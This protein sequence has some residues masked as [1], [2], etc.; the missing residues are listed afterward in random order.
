MKI[1]KKYLILPLLLLAGLCKVH[2]QTA[3]SKDSLRTMRIHRLA[4]YLSLSE[5][6]EQAFQAMAGQQE[7]SMDSLNLLHLDIEQRKAWLTANV[8]MSDRQIKTLFTDAQWKKYR[9]MLDGQRQEFLKK[10]ASKKV[11][12][13]EIKRGVQ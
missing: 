6:Q 12:T 11:A 8:Q 2:G 5:G 10:A 3:P 7:K 13:A 4:L 1:C 9:D